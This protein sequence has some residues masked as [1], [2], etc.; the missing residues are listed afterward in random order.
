[1]C[2]APIDCSCDTIVQ[3]L[4]AEKPGE[5]IMGSEGLQLAVIVSSFF[6]SSKVVHCWDSKPFS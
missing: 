5:G 1:M 2:E 4:V 3:P 6:F